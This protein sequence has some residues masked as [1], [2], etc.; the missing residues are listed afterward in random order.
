MPFTFETTTE[1]GNVCLLADFGLS[2][3]IKAQH[4]D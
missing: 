4:A 3:K 2:D 1:F